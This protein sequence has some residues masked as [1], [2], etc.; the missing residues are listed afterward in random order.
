MK[1]IF[2][3]KRFFR[4][5]KIKTENSILPI[6][7]IKQFDNGS[8]LLCNT[9]RI[10]IYNT[11]FKLIFEKNINVD[12]ICIINNKLFIV[13]N[14]LGIYIFSEI[15]SQDEDDSILLK[16]FQDELSY[17][18]NFNL[19]F[20]NLSVYNKNKIFIINSQE[21]YI[22]N[23]DLEN[24]KLSLKTKF[25][26]FNCT[27]F[28]IF[29]NRYIIM[30]IK[31]NNNNFLCY[32]SRKMKEIYP[33]FQI[34]TKIIKYK[35]N[36]LLNYNYKYFVYVDCYCLYLYDFNKKQISY[37]FK[38]PYYD[39]VCV[40]ITKNYITIGYDDEI[41]I[42]GRHNLI[43]IQTKKNYFSNEHLKF[44]GEIGNENIIIFKEKNIL[45]YN[46]NHRIK[47]YL[48]VFIRFFIIIFTLYFLIKNLINE[49]P[50]VI[51]INKVMFKSVIIYILLFNYHGCKINISD[52][53]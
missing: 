23:F 28:I 31:N 20:L 47:I 46:K 44:I 7:N 25:N 24:R 33:K 29:R 48:F 17:I 14:S 45:I 3:P 49:K 52:F 1:N 39:P 50:N 40:I 34:N 38:I 26:I 10:I 11:N 42:Y 35:Y 9:N 30:K 12:D 8:F 5:K 22:I 51:N 2:T 16:N 32:D 13:I 43:Y 19:Y 27:S 21:L 53:F 15:P 41:N 6:I 18:Y 36:T 37:K 4:D